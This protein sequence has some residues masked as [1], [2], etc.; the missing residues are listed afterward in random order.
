MARRMLIGLTAA[1]LLTCVAAGLLWVRSHRVWDFVVYRWDQRGGTG[2][3]VIGTLRGSLRVGRR[4]ASFSVDRLR[5]RL[6]AYVA[7][8]L[9]QPGTAHATYLNPWTRPDEG[10]LYCCET[11]PTAHCCSRTGCM[12][13]NGVCL[14]VR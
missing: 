10:V 5:V 12:T 8:A 4:V 1:S 3:W 9:G 6:D 11:G 14:I 2:E 7:V 13:K